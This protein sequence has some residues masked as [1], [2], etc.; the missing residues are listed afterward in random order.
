MA[1]TV[2]SAT[3]HLRK[4]RGGAQSHL[5]M[6]SDGHAYVTKC[7]N[8]PQS[9]RVLANE[10]FASRIGRLLSLP[11]PDVEI[12]EVSESFVQSNPELRV[13]NAGFSQPWRSGQQF[14][15]R[16]VGTPGCTDSFDYLPEPLL[17]KVTNIDDLVRVLVFDKWTCN[18]DGRQAIFTRCH[19]TQYKMTLIDNGYCFNAGEWSFPD[20]PLRGV[21]ARN[22]V[23][24][25]VSGWD[26]FEPS[27]TR[28]EEMHI[29]D[30]WIAAHGIPEAWY[31]GDTVGLVRLIETLYQ[32]RS[33][34]REL[35]TAFRESSR[36]PF[37]NWTDQ[38]SVSCPASLCCE[39]PA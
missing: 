22:S 34:I 29:D 13:E 10:M 14:G 2:L 31:E 35:I 8:N 36:N 12:I 15:S 16:Y 19:R 5:L 32:R 28:A 26:S 21:Y 27:L 23:Y 25:H 39:S 24:E 18:A 9:I 38:V 17:L 37:P 33:R 30:L 4:M 11:M 3:Q 6:A 1:E 7:M 20:A